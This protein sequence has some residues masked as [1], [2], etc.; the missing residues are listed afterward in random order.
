MRLPTLPPN[1]YAISHSSDRLD[2][3]DHV[4]FLDTSRAVR[5]ELGED[6]FEAFIVEDVGAVRTVRTVRKLGKSAF[7]ENL[8]LFFVE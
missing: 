8:S 2:E 4:M 5:V 6:L 7:H 3:P 1:G